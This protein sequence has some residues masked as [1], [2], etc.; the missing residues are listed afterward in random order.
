M[1]D[2]TQRAV[3]NV[4]VAKAVA[5][6]KSFDP[7]LGSYSFKDLGA[8][9]KFADLMSNAG[10]MLPVHLQNK[11]ALCMAIT[12]RATHWGFDP[13]ALAME[14]F[15]AKPGGPIGYQAKVFTAALR[16]AGVK[17]RYRYEGTIEIIDK[18]VKSRK[19]N[20]IAARTAKGDRKC[21][22]YLVEGGE[23]LTFETMT[24]DQITI[25]DEN[26]V[27]HTDLKD[28]CLKAWTAEM[29]G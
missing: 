15:Q 21:I 5:D 29:G 25:A 26:G 22:A 20:E 13:F 3:A 24:L 18:P 14:S 16:N 10:E 1:S 17:L 28:A 11:P 6:V 4:D 8:V 19:G 7:G 27:D 23:E 12:M 9:V 2:D